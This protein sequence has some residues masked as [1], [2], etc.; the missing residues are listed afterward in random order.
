MAGQ[1]R[2]TRR[3]SSRLPHA[4]VSHAAPDIYPDSIPCLNMLPDELLLKVGCRSC[5]TWFTLGTLLNAIV[6]TATGAASSHTNVRHCAGV[7]TA[8]NCA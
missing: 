2:S 5:D 8:G 3:K 6:H 1:R 4:R 7:C